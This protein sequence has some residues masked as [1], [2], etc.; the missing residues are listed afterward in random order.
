MAKY[1]GWS[2]EELSKIPGISQDC[3]D[4]MNDGM[5]WDYPQYYDW[6]EDPKGPVVGFNYKEVK[7]LTKFSDDPEIRLIEEKDNEFVIHRFKEECFPKYVKSFK[8]WMKEAL[9]PS[10]IKLLKAYIKVI[11]PHDIII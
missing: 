11:E 3:I 6:V 5:Y 7:L 4:E 1:F 10:D 9:D 8:R 2:V